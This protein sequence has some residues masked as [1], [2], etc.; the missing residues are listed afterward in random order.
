MAN[1]TYETG[2]AGFVASGKRRFVQAVAHL[3][4]ASVSLWLTIAGG[5]RAGPHA[6]S[7]RFAILR[8]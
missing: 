3:Y 7:E 2:F 5:V 4:A 8:L 1:K 6:P